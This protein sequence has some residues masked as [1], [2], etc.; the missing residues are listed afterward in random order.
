MGSWKDPRLL[1][2]FA[3][4]CMSPACGGVVPG[5]LDDAAA[6]LGA[7]A[8][9]AREA[10]RE[11]IG[12][13]DPALDVPA[14]QSAVAAGGEVTL[15][16]TFDFGATGRVLI[17]RDVDI[18]GKDRAVVKG[19][20]FTFYSPLPP[21]PV[22]APG[23]AI[24]IRDLVFDGALRSPIHLAYARSVEIHGNHIRNVRPFVTPPNP[25]VPIPG[26]ALQAG[27]M[28][29]TYHDYRPAA[30]PGAFTGRVTV[31][32]N[33]L[34][35]TGTAPAQTLCQ[36]VFLGRGWG[37]T[38]RVAGNTISGCS[39]NAIEILDNARGEAGEGRIDVVENRIHAPAIGVPYPTPNRPNGIII[40]WFF[41]PT[42]AIDPARNLPH[43]VAGNEIVCDGQFSTGIFANSAGVSIRENA[44]SVA[45]TGAY[46]IALASP[47]GRL[48]ENRIEGSGRAAIALLPFFPAL[49]QITPAGNRL[50]CN[51]V[52]GFTSS[53]ADLILGGN[54]NVVRGFEGSILDQGAGNQVRPGGECE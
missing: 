18:R 3:L 30:V 16:G 42:G 51:D 44:I 50:A 5:E 32:G 19:G 37:V 35:L 24:G 38:V 23:P 1:L 34:D 41:D 47:G 15:V 52:S 8:A 53:V 10:R 49:P 39:R 31:S 25:A 21:L 6:L 2:S 7:A 11:V 17:T 33:H 43:R 36:G 45:G 9:S 20:F 12:T 14:V 13:G 48:A 29:G 40:G 4:A 27:I 22:P 26:F 46:G 28:L 54:A